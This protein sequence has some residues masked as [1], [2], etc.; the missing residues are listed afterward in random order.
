MGRSATQRFFERAALC[1][2]FAAAFTAFFAADCFVA[3]RGCAFAFGD[4]GAGASVAGG[5][6]WTG[7]AALTTGAGITGF[8]GGRELDVLRGGSGCL[9][10][11]PLLRA[12]WPSAI[13]LSKAAFASAS[14][15][16]CCE[17]RNVS[18]RSF[19]ARKRSSGFWGVIRL[20][21]V[22]CFAAAVA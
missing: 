9:R 15:R 4:F 1:F 8:A 19:S 14:R 7:E 22:D 3:P 6:I 16:A 11:R 5:A 20:S 12:A 10:G 18:D 13:S 21:R 2:D 17:F